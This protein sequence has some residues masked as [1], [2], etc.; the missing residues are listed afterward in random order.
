MIKIYGNKTYNIEKHTKL[1]KYNLFHFNLVVRIQIHHG[2]YFCFRWLCYFFPLRRASFSACDDGCGTSNCDCG[3][4]DSR[5]YGWDWNQIGCDDYG[6]K[7]CGEFLW[8]PNCWNPCAWFW[9]YVCCS[10][11]NCSGVICEPKD[12]ICCEK[13]FEFFDDSVDRFEDEHCRWLELR[14]LEKYPSFLDFETFFLLWFEILKVIF[15]GGELCE[16]YCKSGVL[17]IVCKLVKKNKKNNNK[18]STVHFEQPNGYFF[19]ITER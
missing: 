12:G 10:C 4:C 18:K 7:N 1:K 6:L 19:L 9:L 5:N 13:G 2:R 15:V 11:E 8:Y 14:R 3:G 17:F 16:K